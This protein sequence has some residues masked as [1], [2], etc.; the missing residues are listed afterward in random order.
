MNDLLDAPQ[1][2]QLQLYVDDYK[3]LL[4]FPV[5]DF[6]DAKIKLEE[7][8]CKVATWYRENQLLINTD[9]TMFMLIGTRQL[10][11]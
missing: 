9:K 6:N 4:S 3:V 10:M 11:S 7:D 5:T 2:C 8:L 1:F